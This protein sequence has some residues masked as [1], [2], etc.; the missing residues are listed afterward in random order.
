MFAERIKPDLVRAL[1][2]ACRCPAQQLDA[3]GA[4][5]E[6][7]ED[8]GLFTAE[9]RQRCSELVGQRR[10][11]ADADAK[12]DG[13][14]EQDAAPESASD[15]LQQE[16][17]PA[18]PPRVKAWGRGKVLQEAAFPLPVPLPPPPRAQPQSFP[19]LPLPPP[20]PPHTQAQQLSW[21]WSS[22]GGRLPDR[23]QTP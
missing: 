1:E 7:W 18:E 10:A 8:E 13:E 3:V 14:S 15:A 9:L 16:A 20:P 2:N 21:T 22:T 6:R 11:A 5:L 4:I 12:S 17:P 23:V 19:Q